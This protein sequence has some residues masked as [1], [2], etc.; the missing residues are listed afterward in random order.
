MDETVRF[1]TRHGYVVLGAW[2]FA[3]QLGLPVPSVPLLLAAG[4]LAG[5]GQMHLASVVALAVATAMAA[6]GIWYE[7]GRK[8][9]GKV[10]NL[11]CRIALEPDSC[12]RRTEEVFARNGSRALVF[13]KLVPGLSVAA[14]PMAGMFGMRVGRFLLFDG[15]GALV[16]AGGFAG[17]GYVFSRELER[18]ARAVLGMGAGL[19]ALAVAG[20]AAYILGKYLQRQRFLRKLRIARITPE[21]LQ[22]KQEAGENLVV[23]DLRHSMDFEADPGVIP[24]AMRV[25]PEEFEQRH[26]EIPR[27]RDII[28]YCT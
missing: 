8:Q 2:V 6:D 5:A 17:L 10:L 12:V 15:A 13:A 1:L 27:D 19:M 11:L 18:V 22:R 25:S 21:E 4:A 16:W 26:E 7:L 24:G 28:L 20:L 9:G 14:P 3:E 23:I